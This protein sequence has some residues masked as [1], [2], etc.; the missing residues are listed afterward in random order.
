MERDRVVCD[1]V[2][3]NVLLFCLFTF[4]EKKE[5][6]SDGNYCKGPPARRFNARHHNSTSS[7]LRR[8]STHNPGK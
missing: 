6:P 3:D 1:L 8:L 5:W 4:E 2:V 7:T